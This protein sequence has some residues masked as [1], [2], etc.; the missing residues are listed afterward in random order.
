MLTLVLVAFA[1]PSSALTLPRR[2]GYEIPFN[3]GGLAQVRQIYEHLDGQ[4]AQAIKK[5]DFVRMANLSALTSEC[6]QSM[7]RY[8]DA[9]GYSQASL[10]LFERLI[11]QGDD[12]STILLRYDYAN[13]LYRTA[14]LYCNMADKVD[15]GMELYAKACDEYVECIDMS[16]K[17]GTG[18]LGLERLRYIRLQLDAMMW[19]LSILGH[20][21]VDA[22]E[23]AE[24]Y[25]KGVEKL[26]LSDKHKQIEYVYGLC[27]KA[28]TNFRIGNHEDAIKWYQSAL[29]FSDSILGSGSLLKGKILGELSGVYYLLNDDAKTSSILNEAIGMFDRYELTHHPYLAE[30]LWIKSA[31]YMDFGFWNL[32]AKYLD[33]GYKILLDNGCENTI[34]AQKNRIGYIP[35]YAARKR[36][37]KALKLTQKYL[38]Q[39]SYFGDDTLVGLLGWK[40]EF[41]WILGRSEEVVSSEKDILTTLEAIANPSPF[42]LYTLYIAMAR[43]FETVRGFD[44]ACEYYGR[45]LELQR[46]MVHKNFLFLRED[47]RTSLWE[48]DAS[49]FQS[50]LKHS[51]HAGAGQSEHSALLYD[52]VLL[53][54]GLLLE[55]SVNLARIVDEKGT[56]RIKEMMNRLRL[57]MTSAQ[58]EKNVMVARSLE[59]ELQ[60]EAKA[61]G[62][63]VHYTQTTWM[64]V[65][66]SLSDNDVAVEFI[67]VEDGG[68]RIYTA[69]VLRKNMDY[70][71]HVEIKRGDASF[72]WTAILPLL[73]PGDNVYFSPA[74]D[75]HKEGVEYMT[76]S[77]GQRMDEKYNMYRVSSTRELLRKNNQ[78]NYDRSIALY[79]GLNYSVSQDDIELISMLSSKRGEHQKQSGRSFW[80]YLPGTERE[81]DGIASVMRE[82]DYRCEAVSG[83]Y[84]IESSFKNISGQRYG[85]IHIATH[86]FY[87]QAEENVLNHSGLIFAGANNNWMNWS[88]SDMTNANDGILTSAEIADMNL[89]GTNLVV[90]SACNTGQG[91]ISGEGVFG[92]QRAFKKAGAQSLLVSLREVDDEVTNRFM[93]SFYRYLMGGCSKREALRNAQEEIR[94]FD[95]TSFV[96]ID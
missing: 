30:L 67:C 78:E 43:T 23:Y 75:L 32:A 81:I 7:G 74:G 13:T 44:K 48:R 24:S 33:S 73:R 8:E 76:L 26:F 21:F 54:K 92:L 60:K 51:L 96:L 31:R 17:Y 2:H 11:D 82:N 6:L 70:P 64:D 68:D 58:T 91:K 56:P 4:I 9:I 90:L 41:S 14:E 80:A 89:L 84:G 94:D 71:H 19:H 79:G 25:L 22:A 87:F 69:E 59:S 50:V 37:R 1:C 66:N 12:L 38:G 18:E 77:D 62:D 20:K 3:V 5:K 85:I 28:T 42:E 27:M 40:F 72:E 49:R 29:Q 45:A 63:F 53:Q 93:V 61:L 55:A 86:G 88:G 57:L 10:R 36:W 34:V 47:Q 15:E 83:D 65:R 46:Q 35:I 39:I 95:W 52:A 16:R